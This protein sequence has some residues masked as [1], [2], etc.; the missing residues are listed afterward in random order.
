MHMKPII[1]ILFTVLMVLSSTA[2]RSQNLI[3][4][5]STLM[6]TLNGGGD[7]KAVFHYAKCRLIMN[8]EESEWKPDA[9][10]GMSVD[11]YE[12]FAKGT[13]RNDRAYVVFSENKLIE[14][15]IGEGYVYNY[16]K[17]R[18]YEDGEVIIYVRYLGSQDFSEKMKEE[19]HTVMKT[20]END[21]G[22]YFFGSR[23]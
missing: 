5:F 9:I 11:V 7:V 3:E 18:V 15:P 21:A 20:R 13:V 8:G 23:Q 17:V 1:P 12:Y 14:N 6:S 19:F 4:D 10:G 2:A 22:A 16:A